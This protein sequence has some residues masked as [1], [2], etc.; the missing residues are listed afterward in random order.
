MPRGDVFVNDETTYRDT[1]KDQNGR[2][3]NLSAAQIITGPT[4]TFVKPDETTLIQDGVLSTD[5]S[6]GRVEYTMQ[7]GEQDQPGIWRRQVFIIFEN[8]AF[9]TDVKTQRVL[10]RL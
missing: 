9:S 4:Y 5:G 2:T 1:I 6:D 8:G 3:V 10:P 7:E